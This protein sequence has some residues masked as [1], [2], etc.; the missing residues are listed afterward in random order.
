M[1]DEVGI[2]FLAL[3][4]VAVMMNSVP[5]EGKG[6]IA[7]QQDRIGCEAAV[8]LPGLQLAW[9]QCNGRRFKAPVNDVVFIDE[10]GSLSRAAVLM[11]R[12]HEDHIPAGTGLRLHGEN[13]RELHDIVTHSNIPQ[14]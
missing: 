5:V 2:T 6:Q 7:E 1:D 12:R 11:V 9:C 4:K 3:P 8:P 14:K 13:T 10:R